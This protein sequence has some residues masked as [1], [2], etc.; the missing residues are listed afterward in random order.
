MILSSVF[1]TINFKFYN[2]VNFAPHSMG[3][4]SEGKGGLLPPFP[5]WPALA[6]PKQYVFR[7]FCEKYNLFWCFFLAKS[8]FLAPGKLCS[9]WKKSADAHA[10]FVGVRKHKRGS[11]PPD[12]PQ[13]TKKTILPSKELSSH[14]KCFIIQISKKIIYKLISCCV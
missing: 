4:R 12:R 6:S 7:P 9:P 2:F 1:M 13:L 3:V 14:S 10:P 5:P 8:M 11:L